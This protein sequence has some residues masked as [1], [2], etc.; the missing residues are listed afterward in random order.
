MFLSGNSSRRRQLNE[1]RHSRD[2]SSGS[3]PVRKTCIGDVR[4]SPEHGAT[5]SDPTIASGGHR[6]RSTA[7]WSCCAGQTQPPL[8]KEPGD[9]SAKMICLEE[10]VERRAERPRRAYGKK[11]PK[12]EE[13]KSEG[14]RTRS[15]RCS[16][17]R[18]S[19]SSSIPRRRPSR[20][21]QSS[22]ARTCWVTTHPEYR[23]HGRRERFEWRPTGYGPGSPWIAGSSRFGNRLRRSVGCGSSLRLS[24]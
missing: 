19:R 2:S 20:S 9:L 22:V 21:L 4:S 24:A 11:C 6:Q 23:Q 14:A 10:L 1:T 3:E 8:R 16:S 5:P 7:K 12:L 15:R 13:A 17:R 18:F